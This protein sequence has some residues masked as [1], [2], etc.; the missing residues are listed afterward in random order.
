M[1]VHV[2]HLRCTEILAAMSRLC[3]SHTA[4]PL[5]LVLVRSLKGA[6]GPLLWSA[7]LG[8]ANLEGSMAKM[9]YD[10]ARSLLGASLVVLHSPG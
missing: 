2:A 10:E 5:C 7:A 3:P 4:P 8:A 1:C 9:E 6:W